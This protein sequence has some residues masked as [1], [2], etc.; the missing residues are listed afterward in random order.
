MK[1]L[2]YTG[3]EQIELRHIEMPVASDNQC[4]I[5]IALCG[6]C[7]SD[8]HAYHGHDNRRVPPLIL[9]H[10]AVGVVRSGKLTGKRVA[11][12][13][14][15]TCGN[16]ASCTSGREHLCE[17]R[18][19]I[20]MR[21]PGAFAEQLVI[22]EKN[23]TVLDDNFL[24]ENAVLAEPL[25]CA[26]HA[27]NLGL[28]RLKDTIE[29][30]RVVV[31]GG[32]AIGLLCALV[33][34]QKGVRNLWLAETNGLRRQ[35]LS[36]SIEAH[37][38]DPLDTK[39]DLPEGDIVLDAVGSKATRRAASQIASPGGTIVHIG[40]QSNDDGLDTRRL[41][42]QEISFVGTYCYTKTDFSDALAL[43]ESGEITGKNWTDFQPIENG[44][45]AFCDIH[46][47]KALPKIILE[48]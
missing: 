22:S 18:E 42:L 21:V 9:G 12:N 46:T 28:Q 27:V 4:L 2:F 13:P 39:Q 23:L 40:L 32:G 36:Q 5:D 31:L 38:Y 35:I 41:T 3:P 19:L 48:L 8:M 15:M 16:C 11:V 20:G 6:I 29:N 47:G 30:T 14:L 45:Q 34:Q 26:V 37:I 44:K 33:F 7:G 24:F 10:E 17:S 25:A 43:L 1:A